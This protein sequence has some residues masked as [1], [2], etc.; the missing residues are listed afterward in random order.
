MAYQFQTTFWTDFAI[1][2]AF[3]V[4]AV[5]DTYERAFRE[6]RHDVVYVTELVL[7]LNWKC[8]QH[9]EKGDDVLGKLYHD[10]YYECDGWCCEHLKGDDLQ[11][12]FETTD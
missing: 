11:Y 8:W 5:K 3:G 6:W 9:F 7:V 1:A 10:L 12:Y 2:D 4:D